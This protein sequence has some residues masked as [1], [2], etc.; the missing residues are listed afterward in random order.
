MSCSSCLSVFEDHFELRFQ[1]IKQGDL[2]LKHYW[3][4][5][6]RELKPIVLQAKYHNNFIHLK[7]ISKLSAIAFKA[8]FDIYPFENVT[9]I[10]S[11]KIRVNTRGFDQG[12]FIADE[13]SK[14]FG[15]KAKNLLAQNKEF[16]Q[17]LSSKQER[18]SQ[19]HYV[20]TQ[21]PEGDRWLLVDDVA[22]TR[23]S[24]FGAYLALRNAGYKDV[25]SLTLAH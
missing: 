7:H 6:Y 24:L 10:P 5:G 17:T 21:R 20:V 2:I 1:K 23:S 13:F 19:P 4:Y 12:R 8:R 9:Y 25:I 11:S 3:F 14:V 18:L 16:Q 22:T 15:L